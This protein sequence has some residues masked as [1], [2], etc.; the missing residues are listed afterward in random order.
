MKY[1]V[2][3]QKIRSLRQNLL[4]NFLPQG[5]YTE[6][7]A[8]RGPKI[9]LRLVYSFPGGTGFAGMKVSW[10][11]AEAWKC[12]RPRKAISDLQLQKKPR[13]WRVFGENLRLDI[14]WQAQSLWRESGR[15]YRWSCNPPA[16]KSEHSECSVNQDLS[17]T[18]KASWSP[19][20]RE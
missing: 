9:Y 10:R 2:W 3:Q 12:E 18:S 20:A 8:Q 7:I 16:L 13:D 4:E 1:Q 14:I 5:H 15:S 11:T 19:E 17:V 6:S